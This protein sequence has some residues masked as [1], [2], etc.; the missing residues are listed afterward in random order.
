MQSAKSY[1]IL[2][3]FC[4]CIA[5]CF[6]EK[7]KVICGEYSYIIPSDRSIEEAKYIA[8][9]RARVSA[10]A[11][12]FGTVISQDNTTLVQN[13]NGESEIRFMSIGG[14]NVKG[15]WLGDTSEPVFQFSI[16]AKTGQQVVHVSV[17][18]TARK[19]TKAALDLQVRV[20]RNGIEDKYESTAFKENDDFYV[21]LLSPI[22]GYALIFLMDKTEWVYS[23]LPYQKQSVGSYTINAG[24]RY[25][26]FST[27]TADEAEKRFVD[28]Y[29]M[30]CDE[31]NEMNVVY[32]LF[33]PHPYAKPATENGAMTYEAFSRWLTKMQQQD[34]DLHVIKKTISIQK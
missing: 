1:L 19:L 23:I 7:G 27:Y 24:K 16:D 4:I 33:S 29:T 13:T 28:E 9:E 25:V 20:L 2:L 32:I 10:L 22:A 34:N 15:E 5:D 31:Q 26:F 6:A 14:S 8:A 17:C 11:E 21:C 3:F 12:H 30:T 18:G